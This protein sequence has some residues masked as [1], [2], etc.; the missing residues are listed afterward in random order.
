MAYL[1]MDHQN[2]DNY[3]EKLVSNSRAILTNQI[4]LP[5]G[6]QKMTKI[7][8]WIENIKSL[9]NIDTEIFSKCYKKFS[10]YPIGTERLT[11]NKD[12]LIAQDRLI[13][14]VVYKYKDLLLEKCH[15]IIKKYGTKIP[16][17]N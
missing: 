17:N 2:R 4:G 10:K 3:I 14:D 13:D 8:T 6:V 15:E 11:Y 16:D 9:E 5:L 7:L 12:F 1:N